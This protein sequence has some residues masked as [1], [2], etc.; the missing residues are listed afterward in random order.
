M[1]TLAELKKF[2]KGALAI[3][4]DAEKRATNYTTISTFIQHDDGTLTHSLDY[5]VT[6]TEP[7]SELPDEYDEH[8]ESNDQAGTTGATES[9]PESEYAA[10]GES[11]DQAGTTGATES[12]PAAEAP[13]GGGGTESEAAIIVDLIKEILI[14]L[15]KAQSKLA[16]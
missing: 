8:G 3:N 6:E 16:Q 9:K 5:T 11:N 10:H 4:L 7:E 2:K 12:T 13:I 14:P 15:K 1:P